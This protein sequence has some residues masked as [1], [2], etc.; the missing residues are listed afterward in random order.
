MN[1]IIFISLI[2]LFSSCEKEIEVHID[3]ATPQL[4]IEAVVTNDVTKNYVRIT[5]SKSI[6][7][8]ETLGFPLV[9][10]AE[11][12]LTDSD[13]LVFPLY[14]VENGYYRNEDVIG[15]PGKTYFLQI[16]V[17]NEIITGEELMPE[18][19]TVTQLS[20]EPSSGFGGTNGYI[21]Y[22]H[23]QDN[24][25]QENFYLFRIDDY[26]TVRSDNLFN[27]LEAKVFMDRYLGVPQEEITLQLLHIN[28]E[29]YRYFYTLGS[30]EYMD[31][32]GP[33]SGG[34]PGN[35][36]NTISGNAI[37]FFGAFYVDSKTIVLP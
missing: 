15:I 14:Y 7:E 32:S 21:V 25:N 26:K 13:G 9:T 35:P 1:K 10:D 33:F 6:Y 29:N 2:I 23:F 16:K 8:N 34:T 18:P 5:R 24:P 17:G 31:D 22:C 12:T 27:G 19:V 28:K 30:I 20:F 3:Q 36:V 4:V 37:G 11:V